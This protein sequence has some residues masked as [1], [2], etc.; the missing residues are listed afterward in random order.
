MGKLSSRTARLA[1]TAG[2]AATLAVSGLPV[3][4]FAEG[5]TTNKPAAEA[6]ADVATTSVAPT[7]TAEDGADKADASKDN[8]TTEATA[9]AVETPAADSAAPAADAAEAPTPKAAA[10]TKAYSVGDTAYS[11]FEEALD[12]AGENGTITLVANSSEKLTVNKKVTIK[13]NAGVTFTGTLTITADGVT[14]D[15]VHFNRGAAAEGRK[16]SIVV[17]GATGTTV[18]NCDFTAPSELFKGKEW[19][20]NGIVLQGVTKTTT[21]ED[22][23]FNLGRMNDT[24]GSGDVAADS[25]ANSAINL[26]GGGDG[27][28]DVVV[29][30]RNT[31]T[32]TAPAADATRSASVNL[33]IANGNNN[34]PDVTQYGI[35]NVTVLG[36]TF[37][38]SADPN[39]EKTRFAGISN[40]K[41]VSFTE[42]KISN[43]GTGIGQSVWKDQTGGNNTVTYKKNEFT[44]VKTPVRQPYAS[45]S[46]SASDGTVALYTSVNEAINASNDPKAVVQ[47]TKDVTE[48][49]V[50][51]AGKTVTLDLAGKKL[52][53]AAGHTITNHGTLTVT[54]SSDGKT[55]V[56]DN[57][58]HGKAAV[59]NCTDGTVVL[60]GGS[61]TR[62]AEKSVS[63]A[64]GGNN[65]YYVLKNFGQMTVKDGSVVKF[66]DTNTGLYSSLVANGWYNDSDGKAEGNVYGTSVAKLVIEGG[67]FT[68]GQITV[69]NDDYGEL[70][71]AG[72]TIDQVNAGRNAVQNHNRATI[73]GGTI[74]SKDSDAVVS[75]YHA[76]GSNDGTLDVTGGSITSESASALIQRGG[77]KATVS[78]GTFKGGAGQEVVCADDGASVELS[79]GAYSSAPDAKYVVEGSGLGKN[80]DGTFGVREAKLTLGTAAVTYNVK[81]GELTEAQATQLVK[82]EMNV[83]GYSVSLDAA[84]LAAINAGVKAGVTGDYE[85]TFTAVKGG[86]ATAAADASGAL[87]ATAT[88]TL[89]KDAPQ[90]KTWNVTFKYGVEGTADTVVKVTDGDKA[91]KPADPTRDGYEFAGWFSDEALTRAYDFSSAVT[92]DVTLY[93]K[94]NANKSDDTKPGTNPETK[95]WKVT[96]VDGIDS[97]DDPRVEVKD[98]EAVA[99][100]ADPT[101]DGWKFVG[102]YTALNDDGTVENEY[103]FSQPVKG[104]L[105]LY[106]GWVPAGSSDGTKPEEPKS[107]NKGNKELPQTGDTTNYAIPVAL[108]VAGVVAVGGALVMRKRQQ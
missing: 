24:N 30:Q 91:S 79:G 85:L 11:T 103:D 65:S 39:N 73:S 101:L 77:G 72:G 36:N 58:S 1:V 15:G 66:S 2:L 80:E 46:V 93:A 59:Y 64:D 38:G 32:V 35:K 78:G 97:T 34:G 14:V 43:A 37:D 67:T 105:T 45:A 27:N 84:Q 10:E 60:D 25:N 51:P 20:Y 29:I 87:T 33:L 5:A 75:Y 21:I 13:A 52:T 19:Q 68:G 56:V 94:W 31:V 22:N 18:K 106:A 69:K 6:S 107:D 4:A 12:A 96:F 104:D 57:V 40:V 82:P 74:T 81:D 95:T 41:G 44:G 102:W 98:G 71:I 108:G 3:A 48:D 61:Y 55:G 23:T 50:I 16:D 70:T 63:S 76:V 62:S 47:L 88:F 99:K 26:V 8:A 92:G 100:P 90:P 17:S 28:I 83:G 7:E 49:V 42:N 54:D 9:D 89:T 86:A 53:N